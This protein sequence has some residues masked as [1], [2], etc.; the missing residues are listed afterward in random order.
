MLLFYCVCWIFPTKIL[1]DDGHDSN[2]QMISAYTTNHSPSLKKTTLS[3]TRSLFDKKERRERERER[4][5]KD[6]TMTTSSARDSLAK[7]VL[8]TLVSKVPSREHQSFVT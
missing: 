1:S 8:F 7:V 4:V 2:D 6:D 5:E 3:L